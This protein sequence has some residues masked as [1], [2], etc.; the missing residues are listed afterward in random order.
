MPGTALRSVAARNASATRG[1]LATTEDRRDYQIDFLR[2]LAMLFV[3]VNHVTLPS[4]YRLLT[5]ERIGVITGAEIFVLLSGCILGIVYRRRLYERG[6]A[7]SSRKLLRR[8]LKLYVA[9]VAVVFGVYLVSLAPGING[10]V[11]TTYVDPR[12]GEVFDL[13]PHGAWDFAYGLLSL[14]AGPGQFNVMALYVAMLVL[15]PAILWLLARGWTLLVLALSWSLYGLYFVEPLSPIPSQSENAF[16]LL[17]W[18]LLFVH[19]MVAGFH[20]EAL[21]HIARRSVAKALFPFLLLVFVAGVFYAWNSPWA[22][23]PEQARLSVIPS[24]LYGEIYARFF[25]R[26]MLGIGRIVNLAIA[27]VVL[28][29][30]V[31][32]LRPWA[33]RV[34]GWLLVPLGAASLYVFI[35]HVWFVLGVAQLRQLDEAGWMAATIVHTIVVLAIWAM[36]RTRFLFRWIPR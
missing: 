32:R 18:Q 13:Y 29:A 27:M 30:L 26:K 11:L 20:R 14:N 2:G 36:V 10:D 5:V 16:P 25:D 28:Y 4:A 22:Y 19:G 9:S 6:W 15:A 33:H 34:A 7:F 31:A 35:V 12:T 17:V 8:A 1:R 24:D 21:L 3:V 23:V